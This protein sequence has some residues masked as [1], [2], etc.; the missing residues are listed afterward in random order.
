MAAGG[1][2]NWNAGDYEEGGNFEVLPKGRYLGMIV[3]S[4][5]KQTKDKKGTY[6]EFEFD[7]VSPSSFKGR[8]LWARLNVHNP[9]EV[10][11]RIG[12]EQFNSLC[13]AAEM[14]KAKI[15][16]TLKLHNKIVVLIV[17]IEQNQENKRDA[18][19][20]TGFLKT[21]ADARKAA[22]SYKPA[23]TGRRTSE[24]AKPR[25]QPASKTTEP[26]GAGAP[27]EDDIPF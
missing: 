10:A 12:R 25:P 11:Q 18:N 19:R 13:A 17:D 5:E 8:K 7:V 16:T 22:E 20:V 14:D 24:P 6:F 4:E 9:S 15:D 1:K 2:V 21:T 26:S 27:V 3:D 23:T